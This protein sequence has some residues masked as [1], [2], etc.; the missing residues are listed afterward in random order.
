MDTNKKNKLINC[1]IILSIFAFMFILTYML[2]YTGDD[3]AWGAKIGIDRLHSHFK[4]YNGRYLGNL[5]IIA[6]TRSN[7]LKSTVMSA[8]MT[9]NIFLIYKTVLYK[10][11]ALLL[12]SL[13]GFLV[14]PLSIFRQTV[15]WTSGFANYVIPTLLVFSYLYIIRDISDIK[16][17]NYS[18][19]SVAVCF[20]LGICT[21]LFMENITI[22][23]LI[24]N[25]LI[26]VA[27]KI[28]QKRL[29]SPVIGHFIGSVIG[30][31]IMFTNGAYL[32]I[33]E[34]KDS[35]RTMSFESSNIFDRIEKNLFTIISKSLAINNIITNLLIAVLCLILVI[36][37][38]KSSKPSVAKKAASISGVSFL[39][40]FS[41]YSILRM[42]VKPAFFRYNFARYL[43]SVLVI[44]FIAVLLL[45]TILCIS[46]QTVKIRLCFYI[47]SIVIL[48]APLFIVTPINGRCFYCGYMFWVMFLCELFGVLYNKI[49]TKKK[50]KAVTAVLSAVCIGLSVFYI[51][52]YAYIHNAVVRRD[53]YIHQQIDDEKNEIILPELPLQEYLWDSTPNTQNIWGERYKIYHHIDQNKVLK[54]IPYSEWKPE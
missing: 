37:F 34:S 11:T 44:L 17:S 25:I 10:S 15:A 36:L 53:E 46:E 48:A 4:D 47:A 28:F 23:Q 12:L 31:V 21:A 19:A 7:L 40:L 6:L 33:V 39:F 18:K 30:A 51:I 41:V 24:I 50:K 54:R 20:L 52:T 14:M 49:E 5:F 16:K 8:V 13:I 35:Y 22:Y 38:I 29:Y 2:P 27:V 26:I 1:L 45:I 32:K 43:D 3:W 42:W 9:G